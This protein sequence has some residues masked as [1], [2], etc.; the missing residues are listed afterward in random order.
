MRVRNEATTTPDGLPRGLSLSGL[1]LLMVNGIVGAGIFGVPG[2]AARLAGPS[3]PYLFLLCAVTFLPVVMCFVRLSRLSDGARGP[4]AYTQTAFGPL[5][6]FLVGWALYVGR[7]SAFAANLTLIADTV[8]GIWTGVGGPLA[9][10]IFLATVVVIVSACNARGTRPAVGTLGLLTVLK[11]SVLIALTVGGLTATVLQGPALAYTARWLPWPPAWQGWSDAV[12]VVIF[13]YMGFESGLVTAGEAREPRRDVGRALLLAFALAAVLY[14]MLQSAV[15]LNL[16]PE[17]QNPRALQELGTHLWGAP[18]TAVVTLGLLISVAGNL[19]SSAF[20]MPRVTFQ[21]AVDGQLPAWFAGVHPSWRTPITSIAFFAAL[22]W[23]LAA[24]GTFA[25][26]AGL[27]VLTRIPVYLLCIG[28]LMRLDATRGQ[29]TSI[30]SV[31]GRN[32]LSV[33]AALL[34]CGL[35]TKVPQHEYLGGF[36]LLAIGMA[37]AYSARLGRPLRFDKKR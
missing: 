1:W 20:A 24:S 18:G 10:P 31:F 34:C 19:L 22:S 8:N 29:K 2:I 12:M 36:A 28:A 32:G 4:V 3:S 33:L 27:S 26:L 13:A 6:G 16:P 11:F 7:T 21:L 35:L 5:T 30:W 17:A 15:V 25:R 37:L 14:A 23:G 9:R